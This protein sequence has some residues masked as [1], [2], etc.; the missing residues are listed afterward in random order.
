M[1]NESFCA[2]AAAVAKQI[3]SIYDES[4][5]ADP[6]Y[7]LWATGDELDTCIG[8]RVD[9][10]GWFEIATASVIC[11]D[12]EEGCRVSSMCGPDVSTLI[13]ALTAGKAFS[14]RIGAKARLAARAGVKG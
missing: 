8:V 11:D 6:F 2:A 7:L 14:Q 1:V 13:E 10:T 5:P 12:D 3:T 4:P 9:V